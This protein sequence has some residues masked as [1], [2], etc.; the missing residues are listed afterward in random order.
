MNTNANRFLAAWTSIAGLIM[1]SGSTLSQSAAPTTAQPAA[2]ALAP[3][4]PPQING[5]PLDESWQHTLHTFDQWGQIQRLYSP[6]QIV[7]MRQ[8]LLDKVARLSPNE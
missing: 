4:A 1:M 5:Q 8:L 7:Q 6:A 2:S 3:S